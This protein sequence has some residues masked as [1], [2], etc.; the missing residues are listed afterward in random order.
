MAP[1]KKV[2]TKAP[3]SRGASRIDPE[4]AAFMAAL[5]H[6]RAKELEAVRQLILVASP[7][8]REGMKWNMPSFRTTDYFATANLRPKGPL[9]LILHNGAKV[10]ASAATGLAIDD[11][12]GLLNWLAKDRCMVSFAD[13]GEVRAKRA[14]LQAVVRAWIA[15]L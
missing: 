7:A 2:A 5:D 15:Q 1:A 14:A 3:S 12:S 8:I 9:R 6:P 11:P 13:M 4:V 10:K